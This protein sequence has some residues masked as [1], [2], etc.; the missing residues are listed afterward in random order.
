VFTDGWGN[1]V[2]RYKVQRWFQSACRAAGVVRPDGLPFQCRECRH[3]FVSVLSAHGV[4]VEEISDAVGHIN[5]TITRK[6]Y[7]HQVTD[8]ISAAARVWDR[9][10]QPG[11][12]S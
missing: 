4:D 7:M 5:S 6:V 11:S 2:D 10:R 12:P 1:A 9:I 8:K 3:T